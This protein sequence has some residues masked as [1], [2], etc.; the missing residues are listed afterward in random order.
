MFKIAN[1]AW[2]TRLLKRLFQKA[3]IWLPLLGF[4]TFPL[5]CLLKIY[6]TRC[7]VGGL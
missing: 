4:G 1:H 7:K 3:I 5:P 2:S 6:K